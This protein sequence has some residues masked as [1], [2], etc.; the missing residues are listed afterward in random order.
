MIT[1]YLIPCVDWPRRDIFIT[2][3]FLTNRMNK[4][5]ISNRRKGEKKWIIF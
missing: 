3:G 4:N 1:S 2:I 5:T